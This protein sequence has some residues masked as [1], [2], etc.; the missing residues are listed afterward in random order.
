MVLDVALRGQGGTMDDGRRHLEWEPCQNARDLGGLATRDGRLT[1]WRALLRA[2]N[3]C[4][5]TPRGL[6]S[7]RAH[8][9]ATVI[10]LRSARELAHFP[11]PVVGEPGIVYVHAPAIDDGDRDGAAEMDAS[12]SLADIYRVMLERFGATMT[13][14]VRAI[15]TAPPGGVLVHCHAGKD[16]T[17]LVVALALAA[18]GVGQQAIVE[19]YAASGARLQRHF[20]EELEDPTLGDARRERLRGMQHAR[21]ET[22]AAVLD[23]LAA[24]HGGA[25]AY[26][27]AGGL[28]D[29]V[30]ERLRARLV[31]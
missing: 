22:I 12:D 25:D 13:T 21:P 18:V 30:L 8:G 31:E 14:A 1:R 4:R 29:E 3:L 26:L 23:W 17:G 5:L 11:S 6:R 2:D 10:D 28:S 7:M 20:A 19:D 24:H 16:R 9:I 27:R 15:A